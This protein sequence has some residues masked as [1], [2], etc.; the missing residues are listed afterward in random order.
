MPTEAAPP[1]VWIPHALD[2]SSGGQCDIPAGAWGEYS[3]QWIHT[4]FGAA[5]A[6]LLLPDAATPEGQMPKQAAVARIPL[7]F[8]TGIMRPRFNRKDG[9]LYVAGVG[10]GWQTKGTADGGLYRIRHTG[11]PG[12][13]PTKFA[14]VPGG[15]QLSFAVALDKEDAADP[16]NYAV[17]QWNYKWT[18][19][20]GSPDFSAI[21]PDKAGHDEV[22]VK[23]VAVSE[24]GKTVTL[25]LDKLM[26]VNQMLIE[27][28]LITA[29]DK[30]LDVKVYATIN[31]V[32]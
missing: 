18:E 12:H 32:P 3:G 30:D 8:A 24:D 4:S 5:C 16:D 9:Q 19:K 23:S 21:N 22:A 27:C 25:K 7:D 20:Y 29:D 31:V 28:K 13:L 1:I 10:G 6:M 2:N 17:E 26:P 15:V 14:V 11:K